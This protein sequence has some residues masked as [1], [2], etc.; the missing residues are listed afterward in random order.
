MSLRTSFT[1][2]LDTAINAAIVAGAA[3]GLTNT[4]DIGT[5][6]T[7]AAGL[8]KVTATYSASAAHNP[9]G[10]ILQGTIWNAF[11]SGIYEYLISEDIMYSEL[12][13]SVAAV[14]ATTNTVT[15]TFTF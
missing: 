3:W 7:T 9:A 12:A 11:Q 4:A 1:G 10:I 15:I 14:D 5:A 13:Y 6:L 2:A 8:G